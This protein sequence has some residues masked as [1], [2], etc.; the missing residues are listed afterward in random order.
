MSTFGF[1]LRLTDMAGGPFT[2]LNVS[3]SEEN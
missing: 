2:D 3:D 1:Y